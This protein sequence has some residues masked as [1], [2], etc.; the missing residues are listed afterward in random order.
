M[1]AGGAQPLE[2][3][4]SGET[5]PDDSMVRQRLRELAAERRRFGYRRLGWLL[6]GGGHGCI[7][8]SSIGGIYR[9][10]KLMVHRRGRRKR[11]FGT[12]A[13]MAL[14]LRSIGDGRS[15]SCRTRSAM[16]GA[17]ASSASSMTSSA[18]A[19]PRWSI[20]R[21]VACASCAAGALSVGRA[22]PGVIVSD[23]GSELTSTAVLR[24]SIG[25]VAW[26]YIAPGK[27]V[28]NAFVES[29]Q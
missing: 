8:R 20:L 10:E 12:R 1:Q 17:S 5:P 2:S 7:G 21:S 14:P 6:A 26:H 15:T 28:Q 27:P 23:N 16:A 19:W 3:E 13:P 24:W 29:V 18:S 4:L 9:E 11:A 22:L 25:R